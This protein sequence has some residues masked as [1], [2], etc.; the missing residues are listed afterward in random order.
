MR[1]LSHIAISGQASVQDGVELHAPLS[2]GVRVNIRSL[3]QWSHCVKADKQQ[4]NLHLV[5]G[6]M[7][8]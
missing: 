5:H 1:S 4:T 7:L 2:E 8:V 3:V 6:I